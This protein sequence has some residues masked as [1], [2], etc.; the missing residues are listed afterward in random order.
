MMMVVS[1]IFLGV[2]SW[3]LE[4]STLTSH[5]YLPTSSEKKKPR[6]IVSLSA[7]T[8]EEGFEPSN[9]GFKVRCLK[10]LGDSALFESF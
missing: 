6:A 2:R 4:V 8:A 3:E 5:F 7:E 9:A 1:F 10:P